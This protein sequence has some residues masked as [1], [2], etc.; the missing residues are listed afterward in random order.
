M[1]PIISGHIN[2]NPKK[3]ITCKNCGWQWKE[4]DGG[5]DMYFCHK[6]GCDNTPNNISEQENKK[7]QA[8]GVLI[9]CVNTG[10][11]FLLLR[12]DKKPTWALMSGGVDD[13][14]R[15]IDALKREMYEELLVRPNNILF[16]YVKTEYIAEKNMDFHYYE[17]FTNTEFKPILDHEN[18]NWGWFAKDRLPTPSYKG[19]GEKIAKI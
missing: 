17:G 15:P 12:N 19:L 7:K 11:V 18:L 3:T 9:K 6:C 8:A 14:E 10:N 13:G 16:K 1:K 4:S 2:E 5:P